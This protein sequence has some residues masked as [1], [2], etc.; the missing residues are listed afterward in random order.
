[1]ASPTVEI[2]DVS[3]NQVIAAKKTSEPAAVV[4]PKIAELSAL[5][6]E[7][8][9]LHSN[10][11]I[12]AEQQQQQLQQQQQQQYTAS[13]PQDA[14]VKTYSEVLKQDPP[15]QSLVAP[16]EAARVRK[17]SR[18]NVS[19]VKE[20]EKTQQA[21]QPAQT[22]AFH[23]IPQQIPHQQI[24]QA[25]ISQQM[26]YGDSHILPNNNKQQLNLNLNMN[27]ANTTQ[28]QII[29]QQSQ[30]QPLE[31]TNLIPRGLIGKHKSK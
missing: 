14:H 24:S 21:P 6:Q 12:A 25:Q 16:Q 13:P 23:S 28:Q 15:T 5:E 1:M 18:F 20:Q 26:N 17:I 7:L 2:S 8:Q 27:Q 19:V 10:R 3:F 22:Q 9:K 11:R 4:P 29:N 30:Q 31:V